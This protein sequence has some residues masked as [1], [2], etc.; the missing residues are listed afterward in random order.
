MV[1]GFLCLG[2]L[3]YD[4]RS[5]P[6]AFHPMGNEC[7]VTDRAG[8]AHDKVDLSGGPRDWSIFDLGSESTFRCSICKLNLNEE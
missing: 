2:V 8:V 7:V 6:F 1:I 3:D 5:E 4:G